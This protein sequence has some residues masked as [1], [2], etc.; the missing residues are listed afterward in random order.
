M[1]VPFFKEIDHSALTDVGVKRKHNQDAF[2]VQKC[3]ADRD[4][5]GSAIYSSL[6]RDGGHAVGEKASAHAVQEIPLTYVKHVQDGPAA[7]LRHAFQEANAGINAIGTST[8][9]PRPRD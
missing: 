7:A 6:P 2:T 1:V 5:G 8:R 9:V 3:A 4:G